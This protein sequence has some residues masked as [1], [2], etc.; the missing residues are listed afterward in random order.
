MLARAVQIVHAGLGAGE[1]RYHSFR[2]DQL[3]QQ[4]RHRNRLRQ[5]QVRLELRSLERGLFGHQPLH[6]RPH[7]LQQDLR[8]QLLHAHGHTH[9]YAYRDSHAHSDAYGY[10]DPQAHSHACGYEDPHAHQNADRHTHGHALSPRH[11]LCATRTAVPPPTV[12][13]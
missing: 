3:L 5:R 11:S 8:R 2:G 13:S 6:I 10:Q 4:R 1:R 12:R 9:A 7:E